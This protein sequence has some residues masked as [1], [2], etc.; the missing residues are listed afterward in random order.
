[1]GR[2]DKSQKIHTAVVAQTGNVAV[3]ADAYLDA[4]SELADAELRVGKLR[5]EILEVGKARIEGARG[6]VTVTVQDRRKLDPEAVRKLL[7]ATQMAGC[8]TVLSS[9]IVRVTSK[10]SGKAPTSKRDSD[11]F[12]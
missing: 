5:G 2:W 11:I 4:R 1:M 8:M 7:S 3:L 12:A 6:V 9:P 10:S